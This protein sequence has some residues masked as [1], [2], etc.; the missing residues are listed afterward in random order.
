MRPVSENKLLELEPR[1]EWHSV[2]I[3]FVVSPLRSTMSCWL[4]A[5]CQQNLFTGSGA[6]RARRA[7][8][9]LTADPPPSVVDHFQ[10][11]QDRTL[12]ARNPSQRT[13]IRSA[14]EISSEARLGKQ[15]Q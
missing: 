14:P 10:D 1:L 2:C 3:E 4:S 13:P 8:A 6:G 12:A 9:A 7:R 5:G 11:R 15:G